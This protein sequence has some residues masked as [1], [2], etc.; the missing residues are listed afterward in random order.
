MR[1]GDPVLPSDASGIPKFCFVLMV[2]SWLSLPLALAPLVGCSGCPGT[3]KPPTLNL[4]LIEVPVAQFQSLATAART[5][6]RYGR[7]SCTSFTVTLFY[8]V[9][10]YYLGVTALILN[11]SADFALLW[12]EVD[13]RLFRTNSPGLQ[14]V[15]PWRARKNKSKLAWYR[16]HMILI[17]VYINQARYSRRFIR[18]P[19]TMT[20]QRRPDT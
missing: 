19:Q 8:Q 1:F 9:F 18:R 11:A 2:L 12:T 14:D 3:L 6:A 17:L 10:S 4:P 16:K 15:A 13:R 7:S 5:T 20:G